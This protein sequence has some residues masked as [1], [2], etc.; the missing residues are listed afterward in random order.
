MKR[1]GEEI[2]CLTKLEE[3]TLSGN[4]ISALPESIGECISMETCDLCC[5]ELVTLPEQFCYMTRILELNLGS[6]KLTILPESIGRMTRLV[7]LNLSDNHLTDL[8]LSLGYCEGL[9]KIGA[10]INI[11]RNPIKSSDMVKK[12]KIGTDHLCDYLQKRLSVNNSP[13]LKDYQRSDINARHRHHQQ[14]PALSTSSASSSPKRS[15][16]PPQVAT[17]PVAAAPASPSTTPHHQQQQQQQQL[18]QLEEKLQALSNWV[19]EA[20]NGELKTKVQE[21]IQK[22]KA[23]NDIAVALEAGK[24][25]SS[26]KPELDK[27]KAIIQGLGISLPAIVP[28]D[29]SNNNKLLTVQTAVINALDEILRLLPCIQSALSLA[30]QQQLVGLVQAVKTVMQKIVS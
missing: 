5:C 9:D 8:P 19:T 16:L 2:G 7:V 25:V 17:T 18:P 4:P 27:I 3:L 21:L 11:D 26:L 29:N 13:A 6:N 14:N 20:T 15:S 30:G 23:T 22:V 24:S 10:G 12:W 1:L 28:A